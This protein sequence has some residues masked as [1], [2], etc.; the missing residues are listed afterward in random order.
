M[1]I[2]KQVVINELSRISLLCSNKSDYLNEKIELFEFL[3]NFKGYLNYILKKS[4]TVKW[5][6]R[7]EV[8]SQINTKQTEEKQLPSIILRVPYDTILFKT[9]NYSKILQDSYNEI[10]KPLKLQ[11][12]V[13]C[14]TNMPSLVRILARSSTGHPIPNPIQN[15]MMTKNM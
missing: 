13:L 7:N 14:I 2:K 4:D 9:K 12:P 5:E 6:N 8:L 11:K 1:C 10:L 3:E 15:Y